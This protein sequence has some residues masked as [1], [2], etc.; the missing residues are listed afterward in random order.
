M[1]VFLRDAPEHIE[2]EAA[3]SIIFTLGQFYVKPRADVADGRRPVDIEC[4][5]ADL[6]DLF[7]LVV[8]FVLDIADDG[9][10]QVLHRDYAGRAAVFVQN[11]RHVLMHCRHIFKKLA[12]A[13]A[14][15][16]E[17]GLSHYAF[18][19][20]LLRQGL[21]DIGNEIL[22][23]DD[24]FYRVDIFTVYGD[25]RV[26]LALREVDYLLRGR[27]HGQRRHDGA[28]R[29]DF[30]GGAFVELEDVV[31]HRLFACVDNT[32]L[33]TDVDHHAYLFLGDFLGFIVRV[34]AE[35]AQNAVC[36][37]REKRNHRLK[38]DRA[39]GEH[40]GKTQR[41]FFAV[42]HCGALGYKLAENERDNAQNERDQK[43]HDRVYRVIKRRRKLT[44]KK[45][46]YP[47]RKA[48]SRHCRR[49]KARE[50]H[51]DL[52]RRQKT[53]RLTRQL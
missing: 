32:F 10:E 47:P 34:D 30:G 33:F 14:L 43:Q 1:L 7:F 26:A 53:A 49:E 31:Y 50:R 2:H 4:V 36:R 16:H 28:V 9:F 22:Y 46:H 29:H 45:R 40:A 42:V 5:D 18:D 38:N 37:P 24:A 11:D 39:D 12:E 17:I 19:R 51:A 8:V 35:Y 13:V 6:L 44:V 23:I 3:D 27:R 15:G 52:Y 48:R 21:A 20:K 25:A 41:D